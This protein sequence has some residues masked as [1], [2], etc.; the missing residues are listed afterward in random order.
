MRENRVRDVTAK[1]LTT[2]REREKKDGKKGTREISGNSLGGIK[3]RERGQLEPKTKDWF[4]LFHERGQAELKRKRS[5]DPTTEVTLSSNL[6]L[7][8]NGALEESRS[9]IESDIFR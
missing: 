9:L 3:E 1:E 6:F 2:E 8:P 7:G 4:S 5:F